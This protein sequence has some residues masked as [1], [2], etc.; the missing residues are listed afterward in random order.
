MLKVSLFGQ[1]WQA[2]GLGLKEEPH[3][4]RVLRSQRGGEV[5]EPLVREQ[6]FVRMQPLAEPALKVRACSG[7]TTSCSCADLFN[8]SQG[9]HAEARRACKGEDSILSEHWAREAAIAVHAG[10]EK[11]GAMSRM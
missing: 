9:M 1:T 3:T 5:V 2:A 4:M 8:Q 6:W 11:A 7:S 10:E